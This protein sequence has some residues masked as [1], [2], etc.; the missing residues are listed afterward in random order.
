M[1]P[2]RFS[3]WDFLK[4]FDD[5]AFSLFRKEHPAESD[6]ELFYHVQSLT[7]DEDPAEAIK[8]YE[9]FIR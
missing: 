5:R 3:V 9:P 8:H 6:Q 1:K 4:P 7:H 2:L